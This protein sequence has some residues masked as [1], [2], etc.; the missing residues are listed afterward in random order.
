[1]CHV[2]CFIVLQGMSIPTK[3]CYCTII[4]IPLTKYSISFVYEYN[5]VLEVMK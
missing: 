5:E 1:M 2:T 3:R 4:L